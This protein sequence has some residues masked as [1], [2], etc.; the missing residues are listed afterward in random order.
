MTLAG[1]N[2]QL[3]HPEESIL[4]DASGNFSL[5]LLVTGTKSDDLQEQ[6]E[7]IWTDSASAAFLS[8]PNTFRISHDFLLSPTPSIMNLGLLTLPANFF[9]L[10]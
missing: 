2:S 5:A 1:F 8:Q 9:R 3:L 6:I 7:V 4:T 10:L